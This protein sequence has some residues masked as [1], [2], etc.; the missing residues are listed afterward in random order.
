[1]RTI[2]IRLIEAG[3]DGALA[4]EGAALQGGNIPD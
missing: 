3:D 1:M 2:A 4:D